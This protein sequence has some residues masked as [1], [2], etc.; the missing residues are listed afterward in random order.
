MCPT[1]LCFVFQLYPPFLQTKAHT[2]QVIH[3]QKTVIEHVSCSGGDACTFNILTKSNFLCPVVGSASY[4]V[5]FRV[6]LQIIAD[7]GS[8]LLL[9][10]CKRIP[11]GKIDEEY[12]FITINPAKSTEVR[13]RR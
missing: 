10:R 11:L 6:T 9:F 4:E 5:I 8:C 1:L 3:V 2:Y 13:F 12:R 7:R